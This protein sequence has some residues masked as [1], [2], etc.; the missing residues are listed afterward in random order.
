MKRWISVLMLMAVAGSGAW[1]DD[2]DKAGRVGEFSSSFYKDWPLFS[3]RA[4]EAKA[5]QSIDRFGPVGIGIELHQPAFVMK[6]KNVSQVKTAK[7]DPKSIP[8]TKVTFKDG[9]ETDSQLLIWTGDT[10]MNL[11]RNDVL[12][13]TIKPENGTEYL[14]VESGGFSEKNPLGWKSSLIVLKRTDT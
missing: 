2:V 8:F 7:V 12:K 6:V 3:T 5:V 9:G 13:M 1:A 10:L 14:F 4:D 11:D